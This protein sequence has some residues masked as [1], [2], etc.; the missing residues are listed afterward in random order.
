M[1]Y[2]AT[3]RIGYGIN[4]EDKTPDWLSELFEDESQLPDTLEIVHYGDENYCGIFIALKRTHQWGW[5]TQPKELDE[6][7][8]RQII[9]Q[10]ELMSDLTKSLEKVPGY[11]FPEGGIQPKWMLLA[12]YS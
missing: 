12:N 1:G 5:E 6:K 3:A 4:L 11:E 9:D 7:I 2:D 8:I 10:T